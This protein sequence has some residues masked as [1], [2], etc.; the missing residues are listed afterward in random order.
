VAY[1]ASTLEAISL[2]VVDKLQQWAADTQA[3][4]TE[5]TAALK[6]K[7]KDMSLFSPF[8]EEPT[9]EDNNMNVDDATVA[10]INITAP[11][12][13]NWALPPLSPNEVLAVSTTSTMVDPGGS[14]GMAD[15]SVLDWDFAGVGFEEIFAALIQA[16]EATQG[17]ETT[18]TAPND[19]LA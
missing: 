5:G 9:A 8:P 18:G 7:L 17:G 2:A 15:D 14:T 12:D 16:N 11:F 13:A 6:Q 19:M 1:H 4:L 3:D 10:D